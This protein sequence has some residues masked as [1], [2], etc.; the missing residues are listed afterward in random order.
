MWEIFLIHNFA[1][2]FLLIKHDFFDVMLLIFS[3][4]HM[5]VCFLNPIYKTN[6]F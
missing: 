4:I 3:G 6:L 2:L 1:I 5:D